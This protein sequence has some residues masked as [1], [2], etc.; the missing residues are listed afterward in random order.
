MIS[1]VILVKDQAEQLKKCLASLTFC[2]EI[3]VIDDYSYDESGKVAEKAGARVY[4]RKLHGDFAAQRNYGLEKAKNEWVLFID[5]DEV[6]PENL[7]TELYQLTSQFLSEVSGYYLK[8]VDYMWGRQLHYGDAGTAKLLRLAKKSKGEWVG[9]VHETWN[10]VGEKAT[11]SYPLYHYPHQT[12]KEFLQE[13]NFYSTLRAEEL[14]DKK[15]AVNSFSIFSY[16]IGKFLYLYFI[17]LGFL[18]RTPG[19]ISAL[20]MSFHSFLVRG[21]LWQLGQR[22]KTYDFGN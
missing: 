22:K 15:V 19:I 1:G 6:V 7:A 13:V 21:K 17:K 14:H 18:D 12:V 9:R 5:A 4:K 3:I 20:M 11:L 2:D 16:P 8:R 10:V